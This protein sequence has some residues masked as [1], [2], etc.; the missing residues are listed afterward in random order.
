MSGENIQGR[1]VS[2][3]DV[4]SNSEQKIGEVILNDPEKVIEMTAAELSKYAGTSPATVIRFCKKIDVPSFTQLKIRLSAEIEVPV[5]EG[6]SD[7]TANESV[8]EIKTKLLGNAYQSMQETVALLNEQRIETVVDLLVAAPI[9]YVFGIGAS[10]LV[11][12]NIAQKWNRIGKTVVC[13]QDSHVL[14]TMLVSAPKDAIFFCVSHSG[15][16]KEILRLLNVA[17][18]HQLKTIGLSQFGNN[19]LTN[20]AEYSLQTVRSNEAV[21]RSAATTSL[22]D[23]FIVVD[24][25]FYAYASRN[26]NRTIEMIQESKAEVR[27]YEK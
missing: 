3:L 25:L 5:Y 6:Y 13:V 27:K 26:F 9:I 16:T 14:V 4:L 17:K 1:I 24:V 20:Q 23:Q 18:K 19:T 2:M 8:N 11:A 12:E 21:L 15:E 10:Y 7:I 22:H